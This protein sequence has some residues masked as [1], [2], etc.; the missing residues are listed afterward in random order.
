[1]DQL[2]GDENYSYKGIHSGNQIRTAIWNDGMVGRRYNDPT[3]FLGEWPINSGNT[4]I[5]QQCVVIG[6]EIRDK[7]GFFIHIFFILPL[8]VQ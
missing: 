3:S 5:N 4:Y 7:D 6:A 2:H 8:S 1:M